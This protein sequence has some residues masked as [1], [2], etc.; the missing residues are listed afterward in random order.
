M[1]TTWAIGLSCILLTILLAGYNIHTQKE[2]ALQG[3]RSDSVNLINL[4]KMDLVRTFSGLDQIFLGLE[5]HLVPGPH[6]A[7]MDPPEIRRLID[8]LVMRNPYLTSLMVLDEQGR[9]LHWNNNFQKP[10]LNQRAYFQVHKKMVVEGLFF[11]LPQ[12]SI[13]NQGQW[14]AGISKAIR[15][16]SGSLKLVLAAIIDLKYLDRQYQSLIDTPGT[17]LL[18][19]SPQGHVYAE[20]SDRTRDLV[21][22]RLSGLGSGNFPISTDMGDTLALTDQVNAFPL[23]ITITKDKAAILSGWRNSSLMFVMLGV[24]ISGVLFFMTWRTALY[25]QRQQL[26]K[27]EMYAR[28]GTDPL[29][30]LYNHDRVLE[31]GSLE[32][33]KAVRQ[34]AALSVILID[35]DYFKVINENYGRRFGDE[36][37]QGTA[38]I[39]QECSRETDILSRYAG[40]NFLLVLPNTNL[41]GAVVLAR[42]IHERLT[43]KSY[44]VTKGGEFQVT[45]SFGVSEWASGETKLEPAVQRASAALYEVKKSGRNNIR[46]MPSGLGNDEV[47]GSVVW[48]HTKDRQA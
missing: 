27:T 37:L 19:T 3:A 30:Q 38:E 22:Q 17:K 2:M 8:D 28:S 15:S 25:Q 48:L 32:I 10:D 29:T 20:V 33:K 26:T 18:I 13:I 14:I 44:P 5:S 1:K 35:L 12:P 45:A 41:Q 43:K 6:G 46:W 9:I 16:Q 34:K 36:V 7:Q 21:G 40:I 47:E 24:F 39:L 11:S 23:L 4:A 42:K 31:F